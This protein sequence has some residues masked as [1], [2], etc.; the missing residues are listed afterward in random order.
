M[1]DALAYIG[2]NSRNLS[3]FE[4]LGVVAASMSQLWRQN[5]RINSAKIQ[6]CWF[7]EQCI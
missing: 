7:D 3:N 5:A 2:V 6:S 1:N 4:K